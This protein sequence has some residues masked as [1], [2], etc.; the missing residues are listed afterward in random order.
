MNQQIGQSMMAVSKALMEEVRFDK[1]AVT[2]LDWV[3]YPILRFKDHPTYK[4]VTINRPDIT[5]GPASEELMPP[6]VAAIA[7][8]FFDAT[9]V[10]IRRA[11]MTPA[12]VRATL[13]AARAGTYK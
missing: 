5:P 13:A 6:I 10:R 8:A 9:G 2:S 1:K 12:R 11:P 3:T 7:N 4:H